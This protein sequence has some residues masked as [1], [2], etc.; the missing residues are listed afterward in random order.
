MQPFELAVGDENRQST[1][2]PNRVM[3]VGKILN[4]AATVVIKVCL[5][6]RGLTRLE[7]RANHLFDGLFHD[8]HNIHVCSNIGK[9]ELHP[10][11]LAFKTKRKFAADLLFSFQVY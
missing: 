7:Q 1:K 11:H 9:K 2:F 3:D 6:P 5:G 10:E 8:Y 4:R